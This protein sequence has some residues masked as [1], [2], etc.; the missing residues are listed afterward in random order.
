M[1]R[2][3]LVVLLGGSIAA[4]ISLRPQNPAAAVIP[5]PGTPAASATARAAT[6]QS[7]AVTADEFV[8][9]PERAAL[10]VKE[11]VR[12]LRSAD[13]SGQERVCNE[14]LPEL[15]ALNPLDAAR[16]ADG[17]EPG[18]LREKLLRDVTRLW[19]AADFA[20]A[21]TWLADL[22]NHRDQRSAA[23]TAAAEIA[24]TD[25]AGAIEVA[26]IFQ[27]GT[28]DGS[29][30]HLAQLWTEESPHE[31]V[32]WILTQPAGPQ[33]DRLLARIAFVRAQSD[34]AE[35]AALAMNF[36]GAGAA[37]EDAIVAVTRQWGVRDPAAA[38]A[39]V[40]EFPFGPL[41]ARSLAEVATARKLR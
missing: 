15:I 5:L 29:L 26:Q 13:G 27:V 40:E 41:R 34:P 30:E 20:G 31:A 18:P 24:R 37:R 7:G 25:P 2:P 4:W 19:T 33:R 9:P 8:R 32:D 39:W 28:A 36:I 12:T 10:L 16:L 21:M 6:H 14:L 3:V 11:I 17:W 23:E 38:T 35:G 22:E 1:K